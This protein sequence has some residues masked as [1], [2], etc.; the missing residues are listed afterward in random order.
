M[1]LLWGDQW[2]GLGRSL[3]VNGWGWWVPLKCYMLFI[4]AVEMIA[5]KLFSEYVAKM[6][7]KVS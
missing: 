7:V 3:W 5:G 1:A 6:E 2:V 4:V